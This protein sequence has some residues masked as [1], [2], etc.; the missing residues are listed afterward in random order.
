MSPIA[1]ILDFSNVVAV[2]KVG[3]IAKSINVCILADGHLSFVV[4]DGRCRA[5]VVLHGDE[6]KPIA[7]LIQSAG[8]YLTGLRDCP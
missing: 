4:D 8:G 6:A 7:E 1:D 3:S 5:A 2:S